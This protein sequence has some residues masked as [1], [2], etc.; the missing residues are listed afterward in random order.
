MR[1]SRFSEEQ[2]VRKPCESGGTGRRAA[3][4]TG[5]SPEQISRNLWPTGSLTRA[6]SK[7]RI[8]TPAKVAELVDAQ[9]SGTCG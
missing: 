6:D 9:V 5:V 2:I 8:P 1:R 3:G 7:A 4:G